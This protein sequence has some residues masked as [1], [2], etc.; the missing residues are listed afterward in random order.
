VQEN[1]YL[2]KLFEIVPSMVC[3]AS[4]DGYF[5]YLN[6]EWEKVLGYSLDELFSRPLFDF[7]HPDDL[8][9][10]Q[11][12]IDQQLKGNTTINFENRYRCKDGSYKV[13]E[14]RAKPAEGDRLFAVA[15]DV[16][17]RKKMEASVRRSLKM[18]ER[19]ESISNIGSWEWEISTDT[20]KWS[21]ELFRIFQ[22]D[23]N[24]KE[25]TWAEHHKLYHP[26]DFESLC[27]VVETAVVNGKPY[28]I[29]LRA[30]RRDGETRVCI[31][32]GFPE[33]EKD[34]NVVRL[35]GL[36]QDITGIRQTEN[37]LRK[38]KEYIES[39]NNA[40]SEVIFTV[41]LP[42]RE[43]EYVN[44]AIKKIF[45]YNTEECVGQ[46]TLMLYANKDE[47]LSFYKKL[48]RAIDED[49]DELRAEQYLKRKN[50]EIFPA[51]ITTTFLDQKDG[52]LR[53]I[54][55]VRDVTEGKR[56][57]KELHD[58][59]QFIQAIL[60][61]LPIG[62]AVN[63][64]DE[65]TASYMNKQFQEIYGWPEE[66]LKNIPKFFEKVYPDP[67]YRK[68][69]QTQILADIESGDP[70]RMQWDNIEVTAKDG[71]KRVVSAK[72][73]PLFNQNFM[74]STV[75]DVTKRKQA[76]DALIE[77]EEKYR[78]L[79]ENADE[80]IFIAQDD[81]IKFPNPKTLELS[82][83]SEEE[84]AITPFADLIHPE[85]R[86]MVVER[87]RRRLNGENPLSD[88]AFRIIS[89]AN[90]VLWVHNNVSRTTWDGRP[91]TVNLMRDISEKRHLEEQLRQSQKMESIGKLA[92]GIAHEFNNVL[93]IILGNAELAMDD[94]PDWNP[95]KESLKEIRKASFRAKEVVRQILSFARKTM[96]SLKPIE[97]NT[98]VKES[99]KLMRASI[100]TMVDIQPN[101]PSEPSTI[102]GDPT[103]IHQIVINLCTN[104]SHAM[105]ASGGI[106]EVG[107]SEVT[108][109]EETASRYEDLS[110]GIFVKLAVKDTGEGISPDILEKVFEPYFTTKEFGAG[111]GMG[112]AVVHGIIKRC[113]GAINITSTVGEGT[114]VEV[115][116]PKIAEEV[117]VEKREESE[118]PTGNERI[119][120]VD[121]D[122]SIVSMISQMLKRLGYAVT[123]MTDSAAALER[124]KSSPS[125]FDL[126]VTDMAM[127]NMSGDKLAAEL[128]KVRKG[129]PILLCTGHSDTVDEKTAK[130]I[131]IKGFA[132]KPLD[133]G[134]LAR[135]V[136]KA[137]DER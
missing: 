28:E 131:G 94:V 11:R 108:L 120:L 6:P 132:M 44:T 23:P 121:D 62:L 24:S 36:L 59:N 66:E 133:M 114:T 96:T 82:G 134:K 119:L 16:T 79:V 87:Y 103:E 84:L 110:A 12:E 29:E 40:L 74:I 70:K 80:A 18:S 122:P 21:N 37:E 39:L 1:S 92:G 104:A 91:A 113:N 32:K 69:I 95:A 67:V 125:D 130:K 41:R 25:P 61:N 100:P 98:I 83:Y 101:I 47:Y 46:K 137:L 99:L 115:L 49:K 14:W 71:S 56:A 27:Q 124:F 7:I 73:I 2:K 102:V 106:L 54:S 88:Y 3:V 78:L 68:K 9:L 107:I 116:F 53:V 65:G 42:R 77:S 55:I 48:K 43:I 127:P 135:A 111:S 97:I 76:Q 109:D 51:E 5:K 85:D 15:I 63:Y 52:S 33:I 129:I 38:S 126:V 60:D 50:G 89:K 13:F 31:A 64:F 22:I 117:P 58:R 118:L 17:D 26:E 90:S 20:V 4:A 8:E 81:V 75:Q 30:F 128:I 34:G 45:G 35:F 93:G 105:K 86:Q 112:L 136:R 10:T 72:N 19:T 123:E 57:E